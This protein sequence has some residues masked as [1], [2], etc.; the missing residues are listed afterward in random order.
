[1]QVRKDTI[2]QFNKML[3]KCKEVF[4][5]SG[6][7]SL[8]K[9]FDPSTLSVRKGNSGEEKENGEKKRL[10]RIVATTSLPAVNRQNAD[11]LNAARSCQ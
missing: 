2:V 7:L 3:P 10:M 4:G 1:M 11:R 5:R 8:N 6:Q 9:F